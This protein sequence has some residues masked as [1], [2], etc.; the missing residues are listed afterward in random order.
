MLSLCVL[1][2]VYVHDMYVYMSA[3]CGGFVCMCL[4]VMYAW[5]VCVYSMYVFVHMYAIA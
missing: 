4:V 2:Y 1:C 3:L 5:C